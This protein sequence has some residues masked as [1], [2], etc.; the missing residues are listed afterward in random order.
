MYPNVLV[1]IADTTCQSVN[2]RSEEVKMARIK[3]LR[4]IPA[5]AA[6]KYA[7]TECAVIWEAGPQSPAPLYFTG[8]MLGQLTGVKVNFNRKMDAARC[9]AQELFREACCVHAER[10]GCRSGHSKPSSGK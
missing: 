6:R 5:E 8:P 7:G 10:R 2:S 4:A 9:A 3:L 1:D